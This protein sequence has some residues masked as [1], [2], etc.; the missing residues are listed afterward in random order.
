[1]VGV[2]SNVSWPRV[3][4]RVCGVRS[5]L[6]A[7]LL[8]ALVLAGCSASTSQ[9]PVSAPQTSDDL[10]VPDGGFL[11][12]VDGGQ[13]SSGFGPRGGSM[14]DGIDIRAP[15]GTT[16]RAAAGGVVLYSSK[17]RGYGNVVILD[18]GSGV[19]SVYA[20]NKVNKVAVGDQVKRGQPIAQVGQTGKTTGPNLHFEIRRENIARNPV[21]YLPGA[22]R[23][24]VA[25]R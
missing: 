20:H 9:K 12:P 14:H 18:H 5:A 19:S 3:P 15:E 2:K 17:L 4:A 11:W 7:S 21:R 13:I 24:L 1:M 25:Q 16:V 8:I 10:L 6:A 23:S 22:P